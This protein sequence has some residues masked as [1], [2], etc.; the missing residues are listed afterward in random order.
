MAVESEAMDAAYEYVEHVAKT[1]DA[2]RGGAPMWYGWALRDAFI[3]GAQWHKELP[4]VQKRSEV[5]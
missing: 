4:S 1:P 3:A 2:I 5:G